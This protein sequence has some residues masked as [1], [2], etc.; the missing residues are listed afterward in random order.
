MISV[1]L[2]TLAYSAMR[3]RL[4]DAPRIRHQSETDY[5]PDGQFAS[6]AWSR[7]KLGLR[8]AGMRTRRARRGAGPDGG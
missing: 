1:V 4:E 2:M 8:V 7:R 5:N 6:K 3:N